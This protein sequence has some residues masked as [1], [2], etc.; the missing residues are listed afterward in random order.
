MLQALNE[1]MNLPIR[2]FTSRLQISNSLPADFG[3]PTLFLYLCMMKK[4]LSGL[5]IL[6]MLILKHP[7]LPEISLFHKTAVVE[8]RSF[9]IKK[10]A[11]DYLLN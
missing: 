1:L 10:I 11:L 8:V 7:P 5:G 4:K 6:F 2:I 3:L 9:S